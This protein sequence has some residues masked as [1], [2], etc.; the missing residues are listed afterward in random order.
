[1]GSAETTE[2][3]ASHASAVFFKLPCLKLF[4]HDKIISA[5]KAGLFRVKKNRDFGQ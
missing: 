2:F 1:L 4:D 3:D 5:A